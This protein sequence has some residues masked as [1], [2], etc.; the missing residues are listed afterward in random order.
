VH[1]LREIEKF[2]IRS[3]IAATRFGREVMG[4]PRFVFDLRNGR[5]PRPGTVSRV[6]TYLESVQ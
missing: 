6:R 1:V 2:L 3:N 5:E 4:D